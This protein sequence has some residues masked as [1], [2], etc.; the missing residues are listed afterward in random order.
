MGAVELPPTRASEVDLAALELD[1]EALS[2][3]DTIGLCEAAQQA[4][5]AIPVEGADEETV[6][7]TVEV[8]TLMIRVVRMHAGVIAPGRGRSVLNLAD[9]MEQAV[10]ERLVSRDAISYKKSKQGKI[11]GEG[12]RK[13]PS[14]E[15][16]LKVFKAVHEK[17][18]YPYASKGADLPQFWIA[19]IE[20]FIQ[21]EEWIQDDG[22]SPDWESV[23]KAYKRE[24]GS[25]RVLTKL[26][27]E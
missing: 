11:A 21:H 8:A 5:S 1:L 17:K 10:H 13:R 26:A 27:A 15:R 18:S 3:M 16:M 4:V 24:F 6:S 19:V 22:S 20:T 23:R 7:R 25:L 14:R 12:N 2:D 9:T